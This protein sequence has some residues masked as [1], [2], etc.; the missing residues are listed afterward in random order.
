M[1]IQPTATYSQVGLRPTGPMHR[2]IVAL[3]IEG[4]TYRTNPVKAELRRVLYDL[5]DRALQ[6]AEIGEKS[7]DLTDR[8]DGVLLLIR[9]HDDLPKTVLLDRL[10]PALNGLL[11]EHNA[12]VTQSALTVR[13]RVVVHAGEVHEDDNGF[14]GEDLDVAFRL[15]DSASLKKVLRQTAAPLV[16]VVS[17]EIFRGII[18]HGYFDE[19]LYESLVRVRV[20]VSSR[21]RRGWIHIPAPRHNA[22]SP[23]TFRRGGFAG[24]AG[25]TVVEPAR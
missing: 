5:L 11:L 1:S 15:L 17:E 18:R 23:G 2:S 4:S 12:S 8:G 16:L 10:I 24:G 20:R 19:R 3:D 9:P 14:F 21:Q 7:L 25:L 6:A 22:R 13:L